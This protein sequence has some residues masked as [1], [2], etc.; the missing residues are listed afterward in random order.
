ME[1]WLSWGRLEV[2]LSR[3][4]SSSK[5]DVSIKRILRR[6]KVGMNIFGAC[7]GKYVEADFRGLV[8]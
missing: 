2:V 4:Q 1:G 5:C 3:L 8:E 6:M 7:V